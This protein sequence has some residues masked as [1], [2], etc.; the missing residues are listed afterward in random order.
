MGDL[1]SETQSG[2]VRRL[3]V[4][5]PPVELIGIAAQLEA[6]HSDAKRWRPD[7]ENGRIL[8][9][10]SL[11]RT[12]SRWGWAVRVVYLEAR[13]VP[14]EEGVP[15][16]SMPEPHRIGI[17]EHTAIGAALSRVSPVISLSPE[18]AHRFEELYCSSDAG[19]GPSELN[20]VDG[21]ERL[22]SGFPDYV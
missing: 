9:H 2:L 19:P 22:G 4:E 3:W 21:F 12:V 18:D 20:S 11:L 13:L 10:P 14:W 5:A 7:A 15:D 17:N 1:D 6:L 16:R 8:L